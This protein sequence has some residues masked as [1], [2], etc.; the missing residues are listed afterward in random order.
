MKKLIL[1]TVL[2]CSLIISVFSQNPEWLW[3]KGIIGTQSIRDI[4]TDNLENVF[5]TGRFAGSVTFGDTTITTAGTEAIFLAKYNKYG[6]YIWVTQIEGNYNQNNTSI[7]ISNQNEIYI[8]GAFYGTII[9]GGN[10]YT[11][12]SSD[13]I[14]VKFAP[15]G[16]FLWAKQ[17]TG[18]DEQHPNDI[19][20]DNDGS[21]YI[22]GHFWESVIFGDTTITG[23]DNYDFFFAKYTNQGYFQ[24]A[25]HGSGDGWDVAEAIYIDNS[26]NYYLC[27]YFQYNLTLGVITVE[28]NHHDEIFIAKYNN[29]RE[30]QWVKTCGGTTF[31]DHGLD[32][33]VDEFGNSY[34]TGYFQ[35]IGIFSDT[36]LITFGSAD[37]FLAKYDSLG[38]FNWVRQ[39]GSY[40]FD[41]G[42]CIGLDSAG[43]IYI[44]GT[45]KSSANWGD[46]I[47]DWTYGSYI[48]K[49][50]IS[51]DFK[52]VQMEETDYSDDI[53]CLALSTGPEIYVG[54]V[55]E[56]TA[57]FG[58]HVITSIPSIPNGFFA[59]LSDSTGFV[60]IDNISKED[61][62][63]IFPNPS[64]DFV[65]IKNLTALTTT[66][67]IIIYNSNG[68]IIENLK[69]QKFEKE[70]YIN[71]SKYLSG[72]YYCL[73]LRDGKR[74][75]TSKFIVIH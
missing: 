22:T 32:L 4:A 36:S 3:A 39:A 19:C 44:G 12:L 53:Y 10:T 27:G 28:G 20:L 1:I 41:D 74:L 72:L 64:K 56:G 71:S 23:S 57:T 15:D 75:M 13:I 40:D 60:G 6:E 62:V 14:L 52:W 46:T 9:M 33:I 37:I 30:I 43:Y 8:V 42:K 68:E 69:E 21:V 48:A 31:T 16:S 61:E 67:N 73:I 58:N 38:E 2:F 29:Q 51:G 34:V 18:L 35:G 63:A 70:I 17:I 49:Y 47:T 65:I 25:E 26:G 59:K 54:G 24:W 66:I 50:S 55:F 45:A 5:I 11:S 7:S